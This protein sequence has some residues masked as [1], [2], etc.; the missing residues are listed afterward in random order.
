MA[1]ADKRQL[2]ARPV[3]HDKAGFK[4]LDEAAGQ[5]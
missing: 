4:F 5:Y 1:A 2:L 3:L